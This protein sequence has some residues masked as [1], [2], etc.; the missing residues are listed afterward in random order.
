MTRALPRMARMILRLANGCYSLGVMISR[1]NGGT[2]DK[3]RAAKFFATACAGGNANGC[4]N[5]GL[6]YD[7]GTGVARNLT[8]AASYYVK[9]CDAG[10]AGGCYNAG[11]AHDRGDGVPQSIDRA[12]GY[13]RRALVIDPKLAAADKAI[14]SAEKRR[15]AKH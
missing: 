6:F 15:A 9:A 2:P 3:A 5:L 7:D 10:S 4:Y 11:V 13:Y 14:A 12:I 8:T 1:G